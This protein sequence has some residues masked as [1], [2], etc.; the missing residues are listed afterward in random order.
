[1]AVRPTFHNPALL[2]KQAANIDNI[3]NGRLTLNVVSSLVGG[4]GNK[5]WH[6]VR[7]ARR[8]LRPHLR[9][10]RRNQRLLESS[11][12]SPIEGKYYRVDDNVLS[13]KPVSKPRPTFTQAASQKPPRI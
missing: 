5:V 11:R 13:P 3:S 10:A 1:M 4:R 12:A 7:P 6:A 8:P 9:V 2:A